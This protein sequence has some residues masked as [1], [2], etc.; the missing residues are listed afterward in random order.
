[1]SVMRFWPLS[2]E[3]SQVLRSISKLFIIK[4]ASLIVP[5]RLYE[6]SLLRGHRVKLKISLAK[7]F[8]AA[9]LSVELLLAKSTQLEGVSLR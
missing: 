5:V 7:Y 4:S 6:G 2:A 9:S 3:V 8:V 1:M